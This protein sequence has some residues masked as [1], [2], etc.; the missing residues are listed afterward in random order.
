MASSGLKAA[1]E[2]LL[3]GRARESAR[4]SHDDEA[5]IDMPTACRNGV[6]GSCLMRVIEGRP[7]H[8]DMVL[9]DAEKSE[10]DRIALCCSRSRSAVLVIDI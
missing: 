6:C 1:S 9:T 8:R 3:S 5:G 2:A 4:P 10:N 7:D